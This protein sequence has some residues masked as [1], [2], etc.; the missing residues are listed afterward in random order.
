MKPYVIHLDPEHDNILDWIFESEDIIHKVIYERLEYAFANKK[1]KIELF[2][3]AASDQVLSVKLK[4]DAL[5]TY[6]TKALR[7]FEKREQYEKCHK[8]LKWQNKLVNF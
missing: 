4:N 7:Y 6:L 1:E 3:F 2:K 8:I 5:A